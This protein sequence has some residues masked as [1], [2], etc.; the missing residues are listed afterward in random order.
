MFPVPTLFRATGRMTGSNS[1][2]ALAT[3]LAGLSRGDGA[4]LEVGHC[5]RYPAS[6]WVL[7]VTTKLSF[8]T[9]LCIFQKYSVM[10]FEEKRWYLSCRLV[11]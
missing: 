2:V 1:T 10:S 8:E 6:F 5:R 11:K 9:A 3:Y 7:G 4:A